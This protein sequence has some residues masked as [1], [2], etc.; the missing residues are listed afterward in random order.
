M[1]HQV[2]A[3]LP[4]DA[5][6]SLGTVSPS[7]ATAPV[8][9]ATD[10][11]ETPPLNP[12]AAPD[13]RPSKSVS[14]PA[15]TA[16]APKKMIKSKHTTIAPMEVSIAMFRLEYPTI[17][18]LLYYSPSG[19]AN[20]PSQRYSDDFCLTRTHFTQ[21]VIASPPLADGNL[22]AEGTAAQTARLPRRFAH[23]HDKLGTRD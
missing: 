4:G 15:D 2:S 6:A 8:S 14:P 11:G 5:D 23:C 12:E 3:A 18:R 7:A 22:A 1:P 17:A 10:C 9:D 16:H 13:R 19:C 21:P 20:R